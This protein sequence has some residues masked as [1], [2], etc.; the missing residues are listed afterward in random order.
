MEAEQSITLVNVAAAY[1]KGTRFGSV[2]LTLD[3]QFRIWYLH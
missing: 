3:A 1:T 2:R